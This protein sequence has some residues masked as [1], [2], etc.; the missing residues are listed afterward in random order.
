MRLE[1]M[2]A[3]PVII[4]WPELIA[5]LAQKRVDG[6]L[7]SYET[8][9]SAKVW[10]SGIRFAF[11]DN[12]YFGQYVPLVSAAFWER[13]SE[14][15]RRALTD[16]WEQTVDAERADAARAQEQA[17]RLVESHGVR[18]VAPGVEE[19]DAWRKR[20]GSRQEQMI[21]RLGLDPALAAL[22]PSP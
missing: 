10:E 17:R 19:L 13:A 12:E 8:V 16:A 18:I 7:T 6:V 11:E 2:G 1:A 9:A 21:Q 3:S 14:G 20:L 5:R 4:A 15:L 22:V